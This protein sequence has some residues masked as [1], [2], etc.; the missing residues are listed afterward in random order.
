MFTCNE[1]KLKLNHIHD[2][3]GQKMNLDILFNKEDTKAI[4]EKGLEN[5][6]GRL[7]QGFRNRVKAQDAIESINTNEIPID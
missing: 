7:V 1:H 4:L 3:N 6:L 2:N 5:E